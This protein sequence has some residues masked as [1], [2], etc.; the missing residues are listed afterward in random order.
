MGQSMSLFVRIMGLL[1]EGKH[2]I[3]GKEKCIIILTDDEGERHF[4]LLTA[5][6]KDTDILHSGEGGI[7]LNPV[8]DLIDWWAL[9]F[10]FRKLTRTHLVCTR[11]ANLMLTWLSPVLEERS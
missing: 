9:N 8:L 10:W 11:N 2:S 6:L 7:F 5:T 1:S 3:K 4:G